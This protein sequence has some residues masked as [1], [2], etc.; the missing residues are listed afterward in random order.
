MTDRLSICL[1]LSTPSRAPVWVWMTSCCAV[2]VMVSRLL[3]DVETD[4][5]AAIVVGAER[6]PFALVGL[7]P[8]ELNAQIVGAGKQRGELV[9]TAFVADVAVWTAFVPVFV[10]VMVAPGRTP[11]LG[12]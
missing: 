12:S 4:V 8:G 1:A 11:P 5:D 9:L 6:Q 7:E 10:T 2:T 3:A